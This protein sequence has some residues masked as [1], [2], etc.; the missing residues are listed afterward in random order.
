MNVPNHVTLIG[1]LLRDPEFYEA[2]GAF[3]RT[4]FTLLQRPRLAD[5][6]QPRDP[7]AKQLTVRCVVWRD[8]AYKTAQTLR[9]NDRVIV[10]GH[11]TQ[12]V[13]QPPGES[14]ARMLVELTVEAIGT[15]L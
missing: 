3:A 6:G 15:L 2:P 9:A 13:H 4:K 10:V 5:P 7:Q 11:L 8:L 14:A 1:S 12:R